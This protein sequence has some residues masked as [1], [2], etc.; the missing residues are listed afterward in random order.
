MQYI[1]CECVSINAMIFYS[2]MINDIHCLLV[3]LCVAIVCINM[4][5]VNTIMCM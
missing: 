1:L 5:N 4:C 3:I 2:T